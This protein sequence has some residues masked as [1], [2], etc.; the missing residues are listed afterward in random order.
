MKFVRLSR[1]FALWNWLGSNSFTPP[2]PRP[3]APTDE[4][5]DFDGILGLAF[6]SLSSNPRAPTLPSKLVGDGKGMFAFHLADESDGEL[7]I[8]GYNE[9]RMQGDINWVNITRAAYW[10]VTM[11]VKFGSLTTTAPVGGI[12]DTGTSLIYGPQGQVNID[13]R[14]P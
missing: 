13:M 9:E 4:D 2:R 6:S 1:F 10:L 12:M 11:D 8:G 7:A 5:S 14:K 3:P